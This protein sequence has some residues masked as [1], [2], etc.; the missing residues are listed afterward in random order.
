MSKPYAPG[1]AQIHNPQ[2]ANVSVPFVDLKQQ[3]AS[4]KPEVD[5]AI[6]RV[7]ENTSFILGPEVRA[8]EAAF[9]EFVDARACIAVNN[10][11]AALQ[12]ALM[13]AGIGASDE[14]IVPSFT[15]FATAEAV[16][17]LGA[18]PVFVDVDPVSYTVT[19]AAIE[20][21]ITPRTRALIPVHLYGQAADLDPILELA[22]KH[23]LHVI[24][25]AAQ[26]HGAK[27]KGKRVGAL[28][29]AGCFS[30]YPSKN[31]G[32]YGEAGAVVTNDEELAKRLRLLRDHGST[33]KYAHAIVGYNFRMEEI[34]AAVLN[35][36]LGHLNDWN[37]ARRAR[38]A[39]YNTSL[40]NCGLVLPQEM[41]YARHVYHVYAVQSQNRDELQK[42]LTAAGVQTGV[43]YPIPIHLQP[44]YA[45]LG[46]KREELPVTENLAE[47]V[48]SLPMFPELSDEQID[49]VADVLTAE[50]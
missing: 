41:D 4:I 17:V 8:F 29:S 43:H 3:Y 39:R 11:T 7:I 22:K 46:Y 47:R 44:A 19:A 20:R 27:Y 18:T 14:V 16:S 34:Q 33:S 50:S 10:G 35:V 13:A 23:N 5:A 28:G 37:D 6:A 26:A 2:V 9:A 40:S 45:S 48:L 25:D 38:A 42:R 12:L 15:F 31:L 32:A 21:A 24:E 1:S 30:F 49:R 36:K